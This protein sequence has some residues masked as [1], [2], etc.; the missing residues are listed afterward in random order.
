MTQLGG[1]MKVLVIN[2]G[3]SSIKFQLIN[4]ETEQLIAKG[5]IERVGFEDSIFNY[6]APPRPKSKK[7]MAVKDY[8]EGIDLIISTLTDKEQGIIENMSEIQAVGHRIVHGGEDFSDSVLI[9]DGVIAVVEKNIELAPLHNPPN[10]LGIKAAREVLPDVP[11]VGVFDTA[12][13]QSI[14]SKAYVYPIPYDF[15]EKKRIRRFGFHGTSH[16]Y[17]ALKAAE[18]VEKPIE[19]LKIITLHLGNGCSITAIDGGKSVDTSLGYG[20]MCGMPMGTRAGD[21]DP[22][23]IL[24]MMEK[25]RMDPKEIQRLIYKESGMFGVSGISSD[26]RDVEDQALAG[27]DRAGLALDI[28]VH[29]ARKFIGAYAAV[30][31]GVDIVVFTAGVGENSSVIRQMVCENMEFLGIEIDI[32]ANDFKGELRDISVPGSRTKVMV[33]PTNEELMIAKDTYRIVSEL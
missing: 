1:K 4:V 19:D 26:M 7:I 31:G 14:P 6:Q 17:V 5:L 27:H 25:E 21:V 3:S 32:E 24:Y 15:Y 13:H 12:F 9:T 16:Y 33:V 2:S 28:Y 30:M 18:Y 11:M 10:L 22:A 8:K 23:I 20:T 29:Y